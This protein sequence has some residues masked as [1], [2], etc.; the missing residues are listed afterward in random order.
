MSNP[1]LKIFHIILRQKDC[2]WFCSELQAVLC[3]EHILLCTTRCHGCLKVKAMID[4]SLFFRS[5]RCRYLALMY[6]WNL[7]SYSSMVEKK[8]PV[9]SFF[10]RIMGKKNLQNLL[11]TG[12][13]SRFL[14]F[15]GACEFQPEV[16]ALC[17]H[18]CFNKVDIPFCCFFSR[19][20]ME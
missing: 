18:P 12:S 17:P 10:P 16:C 20:S 8:T 11:L 6:Q 2:A 14:M 4:Y 19:S 7:I 3:W 13:P 1:A 15:A 5:V 9:S